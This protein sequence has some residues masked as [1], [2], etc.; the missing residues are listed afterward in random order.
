[1]SI[2][3][4][5][6]SQPAMI[7][8]FSQKLDRKW[9]KCSKVGPYK[10]NCK[11]ILDIHEIPR[12]HYYVE[13]RTYNE[14]WGVTCLVPQ[15]QWH[16]LLQGAHARNQTE[17]VGDLS[18]S[19]MHVAESDFFIGCDRSQQHELV[20]IFLRFTIN[21]ASVF[22]GTP[23]T[24][25]EAARERGALVDMNAERFDALYDTPEKKKKKNRRR[26]TRRKKKKKSCPPAPMQVRSEFDGHD[27]VPLARKNKPAPAQPLGIEPLRRGIEQLW[28]ARDARNVVEK[29][30]GDKKVVV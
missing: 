24:C 5:M 30:N 17:G 13:G 15:A 9:S 8:V 28:S 22:G 29:A 25:L 2:Q 12:D 7:K 16:A 10:K 23:P 20:D 19:L 3:S 27:L 21:Y 11:E 14:K 4:A 6:S 26:R 1:M 18:T